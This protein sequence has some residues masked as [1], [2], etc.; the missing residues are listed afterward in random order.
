ML[1][2]LG[3]DKKRYVGFADETDIKTK[4]GKTVYF[5]PGEPDI[6]P[7]GTSANL[8][9]AYDIQA[10]PIA[11]LYNDP[12]LRKAVTEYY[13]WHGSRKIHLF[14]IAVN[15]KSD[16]KMLHVHF[17]DENEV[18]M[19]S[20][21]TYQPWADGHYD[22]TEVEAVEREEEKAMVEA[23]ENSEEYI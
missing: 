19:S 18:R 14:A 2:I 8:P 6:F 21:M 3:E 11:K 5:R 20:L 9:R 22:V 13:E 10:N 16:Y 4:E 17:I 7:D 12:M 23:F 15:K 1:F